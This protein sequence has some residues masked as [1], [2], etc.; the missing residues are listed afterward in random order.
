MLIFRKTIFLKSDYINP[1]RYL[2]DESWVDK[3]DGRVATRMSE[4]GL[5]KVLG[6]DGKIYTVLKKWCEE[7]EVVDEDIVE[8][9][10]QL[11]TESG[12]EQHVSFEEFLYYVIAVQEVYYE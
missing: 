12:V 9:M 6:V 2:F 3:C 10:H 1:T 7:I 4:S 5:L 8:R 11:Y